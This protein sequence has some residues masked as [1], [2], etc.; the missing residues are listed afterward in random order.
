M[1]GNTAPSPAANQAPSEGGDALKQGAENT[2]NAPVNPD[3]KVQAF[4]KKVEG[5]QSKMDQLHAPQNVR[6][7]Y[8]AKVGEFLKHV[9][10]KDIDALSAQLEK[11]MEAFFAHIAQNQPKECTVKKGDWLSKIAPRCFNQKG[12]ALTWQKLHEHNKQLIGP[13]ANKLEPGQVLKVPEGFVYFTEKMMPKVEGLSVEADKIAAKSEAPESQAA[14]T[15]AQGETAETPPDINSK[16][17]E[18]KKQIED[19]LA[20]YR[21][22]GKDDAYRVLSQAYKAMLSEGAGTKERPPSAELLQDLDTFRQEELTFNQEGDIEKTLARLGRGVKTLAAFTPVGT[23]IGLVHSTVGLNETATTGDKAIE[24]TK[25]ATSLVPIYGNFVDISDGVYGLLT[26]KRMGSGIAQSRMD[27]FFSIGVGTVGL[28]IDLVLPGVGTGTKAGIKAIKNLG[29]KGALKEGGK[30]ISGYFAKNGPKEIASDVGKGIAKSANWAKDTF[31]VNPAKFAFNTVKG[32]ATF[33]RHPVKTTKQVAKAAGSL[34]DKGRAFFKGQALSRKPEEKLKVN[35][36]K[37]EDLKGEL[38]QVELEIKAL[39]AKQAKHGLSKGSQDAHDLYIFR[40][41]R[42]VLQ[43]DIAKLEA[44]GQKLESKLPPSDK[45]TE[46]PEPSPAPSPAKPTSRVDEAAL[47]NA[48]DNVAAIE[49]RL[50]NARKNQDKRR[51]DKHVKKIK[52]QEKELATARAEVDRIKA[53]LARNKERV[54]HAPKVREAP[55]LRNDTMT[56]MRRKD[57]L[58]TPEGM[59]HFKKTFGSKMEMTFGDVTGMG[60]GNDK[61]I[62][63]QFLEPLENAQSELKSA[64]EA[65]Q[66][67]PKW[68]L[69]KRNAAKKKVLEAKGELD[70]IKSKAAAEARNNVDATFILMKKVADE[71]FPKGKVPFEISRFGGD[72]IVFFT[73]PENQKELDQFFKLFNEKKKKAFIEGTYNGKPL[74]EVGINIQ[75]IGRKQYEA[76][77]RATNEK[78]QMK[79]ITQEEG[80]KTAANTGDTKDLEKYL[81]Q[82]LKKEFDYVPLGPNGKPERRIGTLLDEMAKRRYKKLAETPGYKSLEP[83]DFYRAKAKTIDL[84]SDKSNEAIRD[85]LMHKISRADAMIAW[86]KANPGEKLPKPFPYKEADVKKAGD[87]YIKQAKELEKNNQEIN[88]ME[89]ELLE[90]YERLNN[91]DKSALNQITNLKRQLAIKNTLDPGSQ[92]TRLDKAREMKLKDI[93][94][95]KGKNIEVRK[96]D[97]PYFGVINNHTSYA[98]GDDIMTALNRAFQEASGGHIVRDGGSFFSI[99]PSPAD[100]AFD[101]KKFRAFGDNLLKEYVENPKVRQAMLNEVTVKQA[102]T[103]KR[104]KFGVIKVDKPQNVEYQADQKLWDLLNPFL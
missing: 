23:T 53:A 62:P 9:D 91:G 1:T 65:F 94:L 85:S 73:K 78:G 59:G 86:T 37:L 67:L 47:K 38:A 54:H 92:A 41:R 88:K 45:R 6:D 79:L 64:Q 36:G 52:K 103:G 90:A 30:K 81:T 32:A 14:P 82:Q 72:E 3:E 75:P 74:K 55:H 27:A 2:T 10:Q 69:F 11:K 89:A 104:D 99:T 93:L 44:K 98:D 80:Y 8:K 51:G 50:K 97:I 46:V 18:R 24:G 42:D 100:K 25:F 77:K 96:M 43:K 60:V 33:L 102:V 26:G 48:E 29:L 15:P 58:M 68:K 16:V 34:W 70:S 49:K 39:E 19:L 22:D 66:A 40:A 57:L 84:A 12:E 21:Q 35:Q 61:L 7:K 76:A 101:E 63:K 31:L 5:F 71:V 20:R 83:L 17:E 28:A 56:G 87:K 4:Q 13:N 95:V